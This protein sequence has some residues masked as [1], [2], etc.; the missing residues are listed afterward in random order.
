MKG[1]E[2]EVVVVHEL[3]RVEE[4][5][6]EGDVKAQRH[7]EVETLSHDTA[8]HNSEVRLG[9]VGHH[10]KGHCE[11]KCG[12]EHHRDAR[13]RPGQNLLRPMTHDRE[14]VQI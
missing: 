5:G 6:E 2:A 8:L 12:G 7:A 9:L 13:R 10:H 4:R 1:L 14:G 3:D 11:E